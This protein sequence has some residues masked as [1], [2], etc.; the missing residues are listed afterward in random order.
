VTHQVAG[1]KL[2][3]K[4]FPWTSPSSSEYNIEKTIDF[5]YVIDEFAS[6]KVRKVRL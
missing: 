3:A 6:V 5:N 2:T 1:V 4:S